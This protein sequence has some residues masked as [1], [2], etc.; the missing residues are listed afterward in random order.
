M[1]AGRPR[2]PDIE[3]RIVKAAYTVLAQS[4]YDGLSFAK[5]SALS[6]VA[7]PTIKLRWKSREDICIAT[8]KYILDSQNDLLIPENLDGQNIRK[9]V[10]HVLEGLITALNSR[11]TTRILSSIVAAAHFSEP[12]SELRQYILSRR[13][14]VLRRLIHA[15]IA[16]GEFLE[17]TDVEFTVD[18]LNGPVLYHTLVLGLPMQTGMAT[19]ITDRALPAP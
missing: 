2:S 10:I 17:S 12:L 3:E 4:G 13:G 1:S 19:S 15:G 6:G 14:I 9:L 5:I 7:R 18:A 11:E 16:N 8:V